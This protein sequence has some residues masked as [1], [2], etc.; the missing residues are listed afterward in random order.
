MSGG[1]ESGGPGASWGVHV[2]VCVY[3]C[4]GELLSVDRRLRRGRAMGFCN[5]W[6]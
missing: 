5:C 6:K 3:V 4:Q 2:R 1:C